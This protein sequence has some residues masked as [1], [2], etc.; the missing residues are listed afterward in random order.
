MLYSSDPFT[1]WDLGDLSNKSM[2]VMGSNKNFGNDAT[3]WDKGVCLRSS[4]WSG[5]W[6]DGRDAFLKF[7]LS[8]PTDMFVSGEG[9]AYHTTNVALFDASAR[10]PRLRWWS[11]RRRLLGA[12][13]PV[14]SRG[15]TGTPFPMQRSIRARRLPV[16]WGTSS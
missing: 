7:S 13:H 14:S 9:S 12:P 6:G 16:G 2:T 5:D 1:A 11:W 8:A 4:G 15:T 3:T 10:V